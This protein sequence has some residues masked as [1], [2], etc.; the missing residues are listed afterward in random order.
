MRRNIKHTLNFSTRDK[1]STKELQLLSNENILL[2]IL[3]LDFS[4]KINV[5]NIIFVINNIIYIWFHGS[6]I[7]E[8]HRF[9]FL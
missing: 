3:Y 9:F 8:I 2:Q 5:Y 7:H 1:L 4:M 6:V